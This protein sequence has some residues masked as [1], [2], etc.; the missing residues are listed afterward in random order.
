ME[1]KD[2]MALLSEA[3]QKQRTS[4]IGNGTGIPRPKELDEAGT[5]PTTRAKCLDIYA[6]QITDKP[7]NTWDAS[8][9]AAVRERINQVLKSDLGY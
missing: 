3:I 6:A 1:T 8:E 9:R 4:G 5:D 2:L 7:Q